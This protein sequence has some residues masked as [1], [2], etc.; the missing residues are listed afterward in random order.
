MNN[1]HQLDNE[2]SQAIEVRSSLISESRKFADNLKHFAKLDKHEA[3][4]ILLETIK[5]YQQ[6]KTEKEIM[7]EKN[8]LQDDLPEGYSV[9]DLP[10]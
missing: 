7:I 6:E 8:I 10:F 2:C 4:S 1:Q 5:M 9:E 3:D